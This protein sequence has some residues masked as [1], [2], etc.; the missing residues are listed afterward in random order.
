MVDEDPSLRFDPVYQ[1][2]LAQAQREKF[3][4]DS[5][6]KFFMDVTPLIQ[7]D[8]TIIDNF[9]LDKASRILADVNGI[10]EAMKRDIE[11]VKKI[12]EGRAQAQIEAQQ[13]EDA[14]AMA[15]GAKTVSE[16]DKNLNGQLSAALGGQVAQ[17]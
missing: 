7:I 14:M 15:Q 6:R 2:P 12:R 5:I 8:E 11:N 3:G 16:V 9:D 13:K 1:G 4:K 10:P 17:A